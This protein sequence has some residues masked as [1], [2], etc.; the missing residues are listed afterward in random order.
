MIN[1]FIFLFNKMNKINR[2]SITIAKRKVA[3]HGYG[4]GYGNG[5]RLNSISKDLAKG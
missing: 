1:Y 2:L 5:I 4:Y 3:E